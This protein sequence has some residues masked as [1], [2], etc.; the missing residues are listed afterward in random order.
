MQCWHKRTQCCGLGRGCCRLSMQSCPSVVVLLCCVLCR[1]CSM[2][3]FHLWGFAAIY[4]CDTAVSGHH[5]VTVKR[6]AFAVT[7]ARHAAAYSGVGSVRGGCAAVYAS[8]TSVYGS[9]KCWLNWR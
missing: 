1:A 9:S 8:S 5:T 3:C 4:G 6:R 7:C 2:P